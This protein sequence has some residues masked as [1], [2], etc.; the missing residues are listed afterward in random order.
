MNMMMMM[1]MLKA[2]CE[3]SFVFLSVIPRITEWFSVKFDIVNYKRNCK[4]GLILILL[5]SKTIF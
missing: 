3:D 1:M 5:D 2:K 4:A